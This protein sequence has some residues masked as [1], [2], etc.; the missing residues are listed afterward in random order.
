MTKIIII[1]LT[2]MIT[3]KNKGNREENERETERAIMYYY[4]TVTSKISKVRVSY[5]CW[6]HGLGALQNLIGGLEWIHG[7]SM[8]ERLKTAFLKSK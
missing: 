3:I 6:E 7:G 4:S 1:T 8:G 2:I 5:R